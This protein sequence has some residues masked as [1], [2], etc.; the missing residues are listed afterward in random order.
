MHLP[1]NSVDNLTH[2]TIEVLFKTH[3]SMLYRYALH[4]TGDADE[5]K[6]VVSDVFVGLWT[7]RESIRITSNAKGYLLAMVKHQAL[8]QKRLATL[9]VHRT[10]DYGL[11][12]PAAQASPQ[13]Q[14]LAKQAVDWLEG[15]IE[16]LPPLRREIIEL[17]VFGLRNREIA[18]ALNITEKKVEYQLGQAV[19]MLRFT[20]SK[21]AAA[22]TANPGGRWSGE[23]EL[24]LGLILN[25][26]VT[27]S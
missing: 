24:T 6:D 5:A 7:K 16:A 15:L 17:K 4:L 27:L 11:T 3:Y 21:H 9:R 8:Q 20:L 1:L 23:S 25:L 12:Q 13:D 2:T 14:Y 18:E 10:A 19:E 22:D 26:L